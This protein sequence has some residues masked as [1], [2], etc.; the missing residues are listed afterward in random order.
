MKTEY[1]SNTQ[2]KAISYVDFSQWDE[3]NAICY[4]SYEGE[5]KGVEFSDLD[6]LLK[7]FDSSRQYM[8]SF[9]C[10]DIKS[11]VDRFPRK[12]TTIITKKSYPC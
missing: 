7:A 1:C 11:I 6:A 2:S 12:T 4:S 9:S 8:K 3:N 5:I 10:S